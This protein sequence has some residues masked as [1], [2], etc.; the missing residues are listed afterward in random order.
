M[1]ASEEHLV[2]RA[3]SVSLG[4]LYFTLWSVSFYPQLIDNQ[5][6]KSVTGLSVDFVIA[7]FYGFMCYAIFN[8][9][10][11]FSEAVREEYRSRYG[12]K[13]NLVAI[14]DVVFALHATVITFLFCMQVFFFRKPNEGPSKS[15]VILAAMLTIIIGLGAFLALF[16]YVQM[17]DYLYGLSYI[18]LILTIIKYIPQAWMN[19]KRRST[20]GWSITNVLLDFFGGLFSI[21]QLLIDAY[22]SG[23]NM[24]GIL[25]F[26]PKLILGIISILFDTLFMLQHYFWF[27]ETRG[28]HITSRETY[29]P[30][31]PSGEEGNVK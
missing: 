6:R 21:A 8:A 30:S 23:H 19:W 4:C 27:P 31:H 29:D 24:S 9:S 18:K 15:G 25:G 22:T 17:L 13:N 16:Q 5:R 20:T 10:M 3:T 7:S 14:H 1:D 2:L 26:L 11:Y 28:P 12:G